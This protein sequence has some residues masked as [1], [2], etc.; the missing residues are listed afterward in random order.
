TC[1]EE[2]D[3]FI[4]ILEEAAE[5]LHSNNIKQWPPGMFRTPASRASM[6]TGIANKHYYT[7]DYH[8]PSEAGTYKREIAGLFV[9]N[10]DDPFDEILWKEYL[11]NQGKD[12]KDALYLHRL[13][14]RAPY[15]G[16]GLTPKII[17]FV[18]GKVQESG[19]HFLRLDCLAENERLRKFYGTKCRGAGKGGLEE[20]P[21]VWNPDWGLEFAR[22]ELQVV[23]F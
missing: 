15:K 12:W 17:E 23:P 21:T 20:L 11:T 9:T 19:R 4:D 2:V 3:E 5:W 22:F 18:E 13:V 1:P 7:I 10:Y 6:L 14:L 8:H 16:V